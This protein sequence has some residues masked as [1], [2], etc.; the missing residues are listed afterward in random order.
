M[1]LASCTVIQETGPSYQETR[2]WA[3]VRGNSWLPRTFD[4]GLTN[5]SDAYLVCSGKRG[6]HWEFCRL[7]LQSGKLGFNALLRAFWYSPPAEWGPTDQRL[8]TCNKYKLVADMV[9]LWVYDIDNFCGDDY[10]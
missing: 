7:L 6:K 2:A 9:M 4:T 1:P 5:V 10:D 3:V 8:R